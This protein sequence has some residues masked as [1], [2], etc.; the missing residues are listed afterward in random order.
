VDEPIVEVEEKEKD[1]S[2]LSLGNET[3]LLVEDEE[4]VRK[5]IA[6]ILRK[7]GYKV[8][9]AS[10]G[11]EVFSLCEEQEGPIHLMVTDVVMPE[12]TGVE[13]AEHIKQVYPEMKVLYMSGYSSDRVAIDREKMEKRIEFIQKPLTV[14]RLARKIREVLEKQFSTA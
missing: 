10:Q 7:Q 2:G 9:E 14:Y 11:K 8:L 1:I 5:L 3:I 4:E 13:L 6:R 12:M